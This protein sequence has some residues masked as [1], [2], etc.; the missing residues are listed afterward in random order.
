MWAVNKNQ[1]IKCGITSIQL[2]I[3]IL[4]TNIHTY[5]LYMLEKIISIFFQYTG[6]AWSEGVVFLVNYLSYFQTFL[7]LIL[8]SFLR[9]KTQSNAENVTELDKAPAR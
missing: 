9:L 1:Q 6:T 4:Y 5:T 2:S 3:D 7:V 8:L